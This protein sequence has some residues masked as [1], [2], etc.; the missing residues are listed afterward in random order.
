MTMDLKLTFDPASISRRLSE[1]GR[2]RLA[3][4]AKAA[5]CADLSSLEKQLSMHLPRFGSEEVLCE[6]IVLGEAERLAIRLDALRRNNRPLLPPSTAMPPLRSWQ[7]EEIDSELAAIIF[8]RYHYLLSNREDALYAGLRFGVRGNWPF[9]AAAVSPFDL[10][11]IAEGLEADC[12]SILVLSR[13]FGFP[14]TPRNA[15]SFFLAQLRRY[16]HRKFA[17]AR[18]L[19]TYVNPNVGF[20]G[21]S[22]RADNWELLGYEEGVRYAYVDGNYRTERSLTRMRA[23]NPGTQVE[24]SR[25]ELKALRVLARAMDDKE[26]AVLRSGVFARWSPNP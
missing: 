21:A 25:H 3:G 2:G 20:D 7:I 24:R 17:R 26:H 16:L 19:V 9:V 14:G 11:N 18:Y 1:E 10:W 6:R 23:L 13:V 22:Y 5:E 12:D 15:I 4:I 8:D